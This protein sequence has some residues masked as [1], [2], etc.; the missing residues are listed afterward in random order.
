MSSPEAMQV[1]VL[2]VAGRVSGPVRANVQKYMSVNRREASA[3]RGD[4][5][6]LV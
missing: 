4:V 2:A 6:L 5:K 1:G 3:A